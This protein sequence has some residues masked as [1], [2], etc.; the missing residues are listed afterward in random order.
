MADLKPVRVKIRQVDYYTK[1]ENALGEEVMVVKTAY[2][3]GMPQ[4]D[5]SGYP[6]LDPES[7]EYK[8]KLSDFQKGELIELQPRAYEGLIT[9]GAVADVKTDESTGNEV[10]EPDEEFLDV[11]TASVEQLAEWIREERPTVND[12]VQASDGDADVAQKLLSAESQAQDGEPRKGVVD[13]LSAV[14]QRA[15]PEEEPA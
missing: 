4:N 15:A 11:H 2:G 13:G 10:E 8:N 9:S 7:Q 1:G 5:P 6:D 3:P 14:I 12:V